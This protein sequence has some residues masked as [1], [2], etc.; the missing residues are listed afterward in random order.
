MYG[1]REGGIKDSMVELEGI[2]AFARNAME[3]ECLMNDLESR[4]WMISGARTVGH[5]SLT[6][7]RC[8]FLSLNDKF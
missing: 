1:R 3:L 2:E 8:A 5:L 4:V 7:S 6:H